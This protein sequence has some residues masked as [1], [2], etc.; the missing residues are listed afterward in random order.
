MNL[1]QDRKESKGS[2]AV[3]AYLGLVERRAVQ[4]AKELVVRWGKLDQEDPVERMDKKEQRATRV[5][6]VLGSLA[7]KGKRASV[8]CVSQRRLAVEPLISN[9]LWEQVNQALQ[10]HLVL[11]ALEPPANRAHRVQLVLKE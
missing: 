11:R 8:A 1:G 9:C 2:R 5:F 10:G 4:A 3:W 6:Q 7:L